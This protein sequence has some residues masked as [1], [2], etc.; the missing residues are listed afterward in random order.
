MCTHVLHTIHTCLSYFVYHVTFI[1]NRCLVWDFGSRNKK[2]GVPRALWYG[3]EFVRFA[4]ALTW[5]DHELPCYLRGHNATRAFR[6]HYGAFGQST[7]KCV[8]GESC[9]MM[10]RACC[11]VMTAWCLGCC[12]DTRVLCCCTCLYTWRNVLLVVYIVLFVSVYVYHHPHTIHTPSTHHPHTIHTH[13]PGC[14]GTT[15]NTLPPTPHHLIKYTPTPHP[16]SLCMV[17]T[18]QQS[19]TATMCIIPPSHIHMH[20]HIPMHSNRNNLQYTYPCSHHN[21]HLQCKY[22][23]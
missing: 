11:W 13:V 8:W 10:M 22:M 1:L 5:F 15:K 3:L 16:S 4:L 17:Y 6:G 20:M 23:S 2:R 18:G 21:Q 7:I 12:C 19:M 14:C 9:G